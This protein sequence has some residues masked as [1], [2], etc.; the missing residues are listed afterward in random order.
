[1]KWVD[2]YEILLKEDLGTMDIMR[3]FGKNHND[4]RA[5][6]IEILGSLKNR[7]VQIPNRMR[8]PTDIVLE[9]IGKDMKYFEQKMK[10]E[11][12]LKK[13]RKE[14]IYE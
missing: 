7:G 2:K 14:N 13:Y 11:A 1:M 8:I 5:L 4:A 3:V 10:Q 12:L 6:R 9:H